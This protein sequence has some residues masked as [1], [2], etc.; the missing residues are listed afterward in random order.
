MPRIGLGSC[1]NGISWHYFIIIFCKMW[2]CLNQL[3]ACLTNF[4]DI[5]SVLF[6]SYLSWPLLQWQIYI[7]KIAWFVRIR[8][9]SVV[10]KLAIISERNNEIAWLLLLLIENYF[11]HQNKH[12]LYQYFCR[13][14]FNV[15]F[16]LS[17]VFVESPCIPGVFKLFSWR[18][19][20]QY[21]NLTRPKPD[22]NY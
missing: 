4:L 3:N 20:C 10:T 9:Y 17:Q 22:K 11:V 21:Q 18:P 19:K 14:N 16:I 6:C 5:Y 1:C 13:K 7:E 8:E 2:K 15:Y 12:V